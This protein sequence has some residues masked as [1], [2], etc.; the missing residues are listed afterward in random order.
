MADFVLVHGA[1]AGPRSFER[2]AADLQAAGHRTLLVEL[3]GLGARQDEFDPGITLSDHVADVENQVARAGFGRFIL[4]GHSYGGMVITGA[5][6]RLGERIDALCY[7]DAF[8]PDDGQS[9]WDVAS[10]WERD[11]FIDTQ[12][13]KPGK[14]DP[15]GG[16]GFTS[17][18]F[19]PL[20]TFLE[21]VRFTGAEQ[22]IPRRAYIFATRQERSPFGQ[23]S[24]KV[25]GDPAW[26]YHEADAGHIV[27]NDQPEQL[28]AILLDLAR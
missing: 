15:I 22:A 20:L 1:W 4:V 25:K 27:M 5:A 8:L 9:L 21:G 26:E 2:T 10:Q 19:H 7:I 13:Y 12:K 23:F 17:A 24:R 18:G 3:V 6:T 28:L 16:P 14:M 11:W